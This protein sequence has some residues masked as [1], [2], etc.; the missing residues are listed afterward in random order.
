MK[1]FELVVKLIIKRRGGTFIVDAVAIVGVGLVAGLS[2]LGL[3]WFHWLLLGL[4]LLESWRW[5]G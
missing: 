4:G 1:S 2:E 3:F 5:D